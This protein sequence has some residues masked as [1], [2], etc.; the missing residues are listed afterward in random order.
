MAHTKATGGAK[1]TVNVIGKRLG[2]KRFGGEFVKAG[3]IIVRQRGTKFYPGLNTMIGRDHTIF[4]VSNGFVDFRQMT[5]YKREQKYVDVLPEKT[6][7]AVAKTAPA[8]AEV[9]AVEA[10]ATKVA[11]PKAEKKPAARKTTAKAKSAK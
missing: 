1:R 8:K 5:G 11:K 2:I 10:K 3:N 7:T 9:K 6:S 4:A